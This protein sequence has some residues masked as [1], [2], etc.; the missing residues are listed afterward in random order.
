M[1]KIWIINTTYNA[2][3]MKHQQGIS[4]LVPWFHSVFSLVSSWRILQ[5]A[6]QVLS[7]SAPNVYYGQN[8]SMAAGVHLAACLHASRLSPSLFACRPRR[9]PLAVCPSQFF[10]RWSP[11]AVRP[12]QFF[13]RP[14]M[15]LQE[16]HIRPT[17]WSDWMRRTLRTGSDSS[18]TCVAPYPPN[19]IWYDYVCGAALFWDAPRP[20]VAKSQR[21]NWPQWI[22][23]ISSMETLGLNIF[24]FRN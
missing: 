4:L 9:S 21:R 24:L 5:H 19:A 8:A 16:F 1:H 14:S 13:P 18:E 6:S 11:L 23:G 3:L 22:Q 12:S 7:K 20:Q 10:P 2:N 17:I 15:S